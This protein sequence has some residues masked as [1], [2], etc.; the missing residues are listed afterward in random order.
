M[1]SMFYRKNVFLT[2]TDILKYFV[3]TIAYPI[4]INT[5]TE[6]VSATPSISLLLISSPL[7]GSKKTLIERRI[8]KTTMVHHIEIF[9]RGALGYFNRMSNRGSEYEKDCDHENKGIFKKPS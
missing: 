1:Q 6:S 2:R 7:T 5:I 4:E 9:H 3:H 8:I